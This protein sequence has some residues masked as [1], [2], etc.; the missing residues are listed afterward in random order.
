MHAD[1]H[2]LHERASALGRGPAIGWAAGG[3][4][5][6]IGG[7]AFSLRR[8]CLPVGR[9]EPGRGGPDALPTLTPAQMAGQRVIYSYTGLEP[10]AALLNW[11][12]HGQV[13]GVIFFGGNISS[14][15]QIASV[16]PSS[17]RPTP[18]R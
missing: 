10:P 17:T 9:L 12:R 16:I 7:R 13:G 8:G 18:A 1:A 4:R 14:R 5:A 6:V 15:A 3:R 2:L 11:I